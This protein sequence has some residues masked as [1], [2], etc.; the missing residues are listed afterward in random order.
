MLT[1]SCTYKLCFDSS[2]NVVA[3]TAIN[4]YLG[5]LDLRVVCLPL[6]FGTAVMPQPSSYNI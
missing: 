5:Y 3:I 6:S 4:L 1:I 2:W